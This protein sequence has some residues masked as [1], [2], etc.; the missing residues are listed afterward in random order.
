MSGS[1]NYYE[2][3]QS[4]LR[5]RERRGRRRVGISPFAEI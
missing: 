1:G 2:A 3:K 4:G 5:V